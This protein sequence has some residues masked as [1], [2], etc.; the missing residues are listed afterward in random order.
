MPSF[1]IFQCHPLQLLPLLPPPL[2]YLRSLLPLP[3]LDFI[4]HHQYHH[5]R[6]SCFVLVAITVARAAQLISPLPAILVRI[7][8]RFETIITFD[9]LLHFMPPTGTPHLT[10]NLNSSHLI[11]CQLLKLVCLTIF[12]TSRNYQS[13][14]INPCHYDSCPILLLDLHQSYEYFRTLQILGLLSHFHCGHFDL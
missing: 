4:Q 12:P 5:L 13:D 8:Q 11:T 14:V 6:L 1:L 10:I 7:E 9:D 2:H 3:R